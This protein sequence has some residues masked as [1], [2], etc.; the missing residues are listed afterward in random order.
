MTIQTQRRSA[1]QGPLRGDTRAPHRPRRGAFTLVELLVVIAIIG[2]LI[3]LLLPAVQAAREAAR[4]LQCTNNV[5][6]VALAVHNYHAAFQQ[7]PP[8]YGYSAGDYGGH[9]ENGA[10]WPWIPRVYAFLGHEP[11]AALID[12][13]LK[14]GNPIDTWTEQDRAPMEAQLSVLHCPSDGNARILFD[15][16][17][18]SWGKR[19]VNGRSSYAGNFG[20]KALEAPFTSDPATSRVRGVFLQNWGANFSEIRDGTS[21]TLL[22]S[23]LIIGHTLTVRGSVA[24]DEGPVFMVD[25]TPNDRTADLTRWCD[26][27]DAHTTAS[28]APC[29]Y[30]GNTLGGGVLGNNLNMVLHTSRSMHPGGVVVSLCDGS[31]QFVS[32]SIDSELWKFLGSSAGG[33]LVDSNAY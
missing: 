6:Q 32:Q 23:E 13:E 28:P 25:S 33:E 19:M 5:K 10:E 31:A 15:A 27:R 24:Y 26:K 7:F 20:L 12:W 21:N 16:R 8:G 9:N 3:V 11:L 18:S 29:Q 2:I 22:T 30:K 4:R 17:E 14:T 1:L